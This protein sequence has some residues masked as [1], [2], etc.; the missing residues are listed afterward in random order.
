MFQFMR[1]HRCHYR[2]AARAAG[3][4]RR[5]VKTVNEQDVL[6]NAEEQLEGALGRIELEGLFDITKNYWGKSHY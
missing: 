5:E 4:G 3:G 6:D 2:D 1:Y